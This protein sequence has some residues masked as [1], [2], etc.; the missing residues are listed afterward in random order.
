VRQILKRTGTTAI[1]VTHDQEEAM[2]FADRIA[3]MRSGNLEQVG[4][5]EGVYG[6]SRDRLRRQSFLGRTN[7]LRGEGHG[8]VART[9]LGDVALAKPAQGQVLALGAP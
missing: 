3:V 9:P 6:Q 2:T 8:A 4:S 7:L 1:L 5:P